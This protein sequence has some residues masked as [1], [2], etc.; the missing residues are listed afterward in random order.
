MTDLEPARS[1]WWRKSSFAHAIAGPTA[2]EALNATNTLAVE[3]QPGGGSKTGDLR[4]VGHQSRIFSLWITQSETGFRTTPKFEADVFTIRFTGRGGA[5]RRNQSTEVIAGPGQAMFVAYEQMRYEEMI[6]PFEAVSATVTRSGLL[7]AYE[8]LEGRPA[9]RL[10][11]FVPVIDVVTAPLRAIE[12]TMRTMHR[13]LC[14]Q[15]AGLD[16]TI[17]LLEEV[18]AFQVLSAWPTIDG[19]RR[20]LATVSH[21]R[22]REA[23]A[24]IEANLARHLTIADIARACGVSARTLHTAFRR[25]TGRSPVQFVIDLRFE[26]VHQELLVATAAD[27]TVSQIAFRWGFTHMSDFSRQYRRRYGRS[28]SE[29]LRS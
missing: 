18:L 16:L 22:M 13:H 5:L 28:P 12:M 24:F 3:F 26:R 17:P 10:P 1:P 29:T 6:G 2:L 8:T 23:I 7:A 11:V 15:H 19:P 9:P 25:E 21:A 20:V 4:L 14:A 27:A